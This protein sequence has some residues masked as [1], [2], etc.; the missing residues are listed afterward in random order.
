[1]P[2]SSPHIFHTHRRQAAV[3]RPY[4][5]HLGSTPPH[6]RRLQG[7]GQVSPA[8]AC[9]LLPSRHSKAR[10]KAHPQLCISSFSCPRLGAVLYTRE[11]Y[12][13]T[14]G[15]PRE[16]G[17]KCGLT[18]GAGVAFPRTP[19]FSPGADLGVSS[20]PGASLPLWLP[21]GEL[22]G[23]GRGE[24]RGRRGPL[25]A[26]ESWGQVSEKSCRAPHVSYRR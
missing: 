25:G 19:K 17:L 9:K 15:G 26:T 14:K 20:A 4:G 16:P 7:A 22:D 3:S 1:M 21:L 12:E 18:G 11:A 8:Q 5:S 13:G 2:L 6:R 24:K 10:A 23:S